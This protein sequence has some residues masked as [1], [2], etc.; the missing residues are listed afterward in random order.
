MDT[1]E[2][3]YLVVGAGAVGMGFV[4]TLLDE[5][6]DCHVVIIDR[7]A[8]PGGHWN[9]SYPFVTL[10]QPSATYGLNSAQLGDETID[11][12]GANAGLYGLATGTEVCAYY[13]RAMDRKFLAS[14]RV[15]YFPMSDY[16]GGKDKEH[17]FA[18]LVSG[19]QT[20]VNIRHKMVNASAFTAS[21][22]ATHDRKFKVSDGVRVTTPGDL[23]KEWIGGAKPPSH[24]VILGAGKTAMDVGVWLLENG[25]DPDTVIW[26]RPRETWAINRRY[27]QPGPEFVEG[28]LDYQITQ[29]EAA[30]TATSADEIFLA[31]EAKGM[32]LRLDPEI[33]PTKFHFPTISKG[34]V[35]LLRRITN[36]QRIG[37]LSAIEKGRMIGVDGDAQVP[38]D[39]LYIDC[40]ATAAKRIAPTPV[41]Q[42][43][44]IVPQLAFVPLVSFCAS[45]AAF[46]EVHFDDDETRN[47]LARTTAM[48]DSVHDYPAALLTNTLNRVA[49]SMNEKVGS[50]LKTTRLDPAARAGAAIAQSKPEAAKMLG[51]VRSSTMAAIPNLQ[52]LA[53]AR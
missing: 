45:L 20:T 15:K 14:G 18:S 33:L 51:H 2:T 13:Q 34:E 36:I 41:F 52:K 23:P 50:W 10:H 40:T 5:D 48:T 25:V 29:M 42:G 24:Y 17:R 53:A 46:L 19:K 28:T 32:V 11:E 21:V 8:K 43:D 1:I 47:M 35:D 16:L 39:T 4:D 31:L 49:W 3:D 38:D 26:V 30:A 37:R 27:T 9:V 6:P 7:H 44:T 22:P 12:S